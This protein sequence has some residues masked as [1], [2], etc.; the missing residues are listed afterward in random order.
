VCLLDK[1]QASDNVSAR[2]CGS[3]QGK[4][5]PISRGGW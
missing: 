4:I 1:P 5:T 2:L 3:L